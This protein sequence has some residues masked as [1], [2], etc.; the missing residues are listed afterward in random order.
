MPIRRT[1]F[2]KLI[3]IVY[4]IESKMAKNIL[5]FLENETTN[6]IQIKYKKRKEKRHSRLILLNSSLCE[7]LN[8]SKF[9]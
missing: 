3:V 5:S 8:T 7:D 9:L 1:D 2:S 6:K 4:I